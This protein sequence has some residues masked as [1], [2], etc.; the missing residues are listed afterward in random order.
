MW[1]R[2]N[3]TDAVLMVSVGQVLLPVYFLDGQEYPSFY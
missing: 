3:T 1:F 2:Q